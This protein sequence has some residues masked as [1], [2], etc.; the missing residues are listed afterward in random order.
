MAIYKQRMEKQL[1]KRADGFATTL[2]SIGDAVITVEINGLITFMNLVAE[3]LTGWKEKEAL[4]RRLT[5][6][7]HI[8][9]KETSEAVSEPDRGHAEW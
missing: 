6:V 8:V 7:F 4:G 5:E 3:R 1:T 2:K 9:D